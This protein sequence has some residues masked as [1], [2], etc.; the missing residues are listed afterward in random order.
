MELLSS[1]TI[2][3]IIARLEEKGN[4]LK[5]FFWLIDK[6]SSQTYFDWILSQVKLNQITISALGKN[7]SLRENVWDILIESMEH[8]WRIL[9]LPDYPELSRGILSVPDYPELQRESIQ[10]QYC[11]YL[12]IPCSKG[13]TVCIWLSWAPKGKHSTWIFSLPDYLALQ[14]ESIQCEYCLYL[15]IPSS[16][17]REFSVNIVS[18]WLSRA[19]KGEHPGEILS[20]PD[21]PD[22]QREYCLS[23][24]IPSSKGRVSNVNFVSSWLSWAP[25]GKLRRGIFSIPDYPELQGESIQGQYCLSLIIPSSK[26]EHPREI[27]S[28]P[29]Y[30]ELQG[31][32]IHGEDGFPPRLDNSRHHLVKLLRILPW[33]L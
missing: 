27:L 6:L 11:P 4:C 19:P 24:I 7:Y 21:C 15:I 16:K 18:T 30:P 23:L 8:P 13:N 28:L 22:L 32:C 1:L 31:E 9:S 10:G 14:R 12:I 3:D 29:D 5:I 25:R 26:E 33:F 20:L 17:G 2:T